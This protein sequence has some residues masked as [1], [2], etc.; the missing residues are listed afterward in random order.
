M[1]S[2]SSC[3]K[4]MSPKNI[5]LQTSLPQKRR[6]LEKQKHRSR[7]SKACTQALATSARGIREF[8]TSRSLSSTPS[9]NWAE[10][11]F[12]WGG[13][14]ESGPG[15]V[16]KI[17]LKTSKIVFKTELLKFCYIFLVVLVVLGWVGFGLVFLFWNGFWFLVVIG[18]WIW[19]VSLSLVDAQFQVQETAAL[20]IGPEKFMFSLANL[21]ANKRPI[22]YLNFKA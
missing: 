21:K 10:V 19:G 2:F 9:F 14:M 15:S 17:L 6:R 3:Q 12:G 4:C 18:Y 8:F 1:C 20:Q 7:A 11:S 13:G 22:R 16:G 5:D